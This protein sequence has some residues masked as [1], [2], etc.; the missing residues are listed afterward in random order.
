MSYLSPYIITN[1]R[2]NDVKTQ[3]WDTFTWPLLPWKSN[4]HYILSVCVCSLSYE[5][6]TM[7]V[8]YYIVLC[9]L[10]GSTTLFHIIW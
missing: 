5:A 6:C 7:H 3:Q 4:K 8:P 1:R 2:G 9:G 10:S